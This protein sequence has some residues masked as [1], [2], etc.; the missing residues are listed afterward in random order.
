MGSTHPILEHR[1]GLVGIGECVQVKDSR[2][3]VKEGVEDLLSQTIAAAL[4]MKL[5]AEKA[6][7]KAQ[8]IEAQTRQRKSSGTPQA[9]QLA[10]PRGRGDCQE[11]KA[12][13]TYDGHSLAE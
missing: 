13:A 3:I 2:L 8:R 10:R 6:L 11:G 12:R 9:L 4:N 5:I 1:E 7:S